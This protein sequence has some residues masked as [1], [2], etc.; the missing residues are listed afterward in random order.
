[1]WQ[2][3]RRRG[4]YVTKRQSEPAIIGGEK[5]CLYRERSTQAKLISRGGPSADHI[6]DVMWKTARNPHNLDAFEVM[7]RSCHILLLQISIVERKIM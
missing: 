1:M 6:V 7:G 5:T 4:D 3:G 2:S